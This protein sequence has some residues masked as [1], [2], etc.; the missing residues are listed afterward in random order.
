MNIDELRPAGGRSRCTVVDA[1]CDLCGAIRAYEG[2]KVWPTLLCAARCRPHRTPHAVVGA[3]PDREF[4]MKDAQYRNRDQLRDYLELVDALEALG[5]LVAD[6]DTP[7]LGWRPARPV[8][9][10]AYSLLAAP[11]TDRPSLL[12]VFNPTAGLKAR[13]KGAQEALA[14]L[15]VER[16][17]RVMKTAEP[18]SLTRDFAELGVRPLFYPIPPRP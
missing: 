6:E 3:V 11:D 13:L 15:A 4:L 9:G 5:V 8:P 7:G 1:M 14:M 10:R 2:R 16:G 12:L 18:W 17:R